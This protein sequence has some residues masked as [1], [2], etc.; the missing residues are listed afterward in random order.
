[1]EQ[2]VEMTEQTNEVT[3]DTAVDEASTSTA[4]AEDNPA[5]EEQTSTDSD[6]VESTADGAT[7]VENTASAVVFT[8]V[9]NGK[10]MPIGADQV[11]EVTTLLQM[12]MKYRDT[13][14]MRE[15]LHALA[16]L[17]G[18]K[19]ADE[20]VKATLEA[21]EQ[22][23]LNA[24]IAK[25]GQEDGRIIYEAQKAERMKK[26]GTY[27]SNEDAADAAA[28]T[29]LDERMANEFVA[30]QEYHPEFTSIKDV[31]LS[32]IREADAKGITL[33][34]AMNRYVIKNQRAAS[35]AQQK[36][37]QNAKETTGS[38][39]DQAGGGSDPVMEAFV[40]SVRRR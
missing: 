35:A 4:T 28:R 14:E 25:H 5:A 33:L 29:A 27:K 36:Q 26:F 13:A 38:V 16:N 8:P 6:G 34:D 23:L 9:Y 39:A 31:P 22:E 19:T 24:A 32:V 17:F 20:F 7:A 40:S 12:G 2:T 18:M 3:T 37:T 11:D 21:K 30:M 15:N 10:A 1:M